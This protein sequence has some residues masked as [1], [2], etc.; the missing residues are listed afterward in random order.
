M[1]GTSSSLVE[2]A[3]TLLSTLSSSALL[4]RPSPS[5]SN[6]LNASRSFCVSMLIE[7][8]GEA[9]EERRES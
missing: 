3:P 2:F 8:W 6:R 9:G 4:I 5:R 7:R 1:L